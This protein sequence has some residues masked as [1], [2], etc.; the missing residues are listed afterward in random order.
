MVVK[1][2]DIFGYGAAVCLVIT[3]LPQLYYTWQTKH[4]LDISYGFL[5]LQILTCTLF[6]TYGIILKELPI[7]IANCV[8]LT[9][10]FILLFFRY[11]FSVNNK[12]SPIF[13][14]NI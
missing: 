7:I 2:K 5:C 14:A 12:I 4:V 13:V 9:Q 3:L 1:I 6:L 8:V 10:T 11:K